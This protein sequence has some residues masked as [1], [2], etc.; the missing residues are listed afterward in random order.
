M[1]PSITIITPFYNSERFITDTIESVLNQTL[2][3]WEWILVDDCSTDSSPQ[4][5]ENY[6]VRDN[7]FIIVR[8]PENA[9]VGVARNVGLKKARGRYICFVDS[10]DCWLPQK[11]KIQIEFM[12]KN[13]YPISFTASQLIDDQG[14]V[15][16]RIMQVAESLD[17]KQYLK[18][19][20]IGFSTCMIDRTM[21]GDF[22]IIDMKTNE[23]G[24]LWIELLGRGHKAYGIDQILVH[25][26]VHGKSLS[27]SKLRT[28]MGTWHLYYSVE[29]FGFF[30]SLYYFLH[31][32]Y[33][34]IKKHYM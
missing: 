12:Q 15:L 8:L 5:V 25:Y 1:I 30:R 27:S 3:D 6:A 14:N 20:I 31:Y 7:R 22:D 11:L 29:K 26:R 32:A 9:G 10:D 4:I 2:T 16:D 17:L 19:T 34:G 18:N 13:H 24:H 23:D 33:N 28:A 21:T